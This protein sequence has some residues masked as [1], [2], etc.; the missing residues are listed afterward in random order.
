MNDDLDGLPASPSSSRNANAGWERATIEKLL[1]ATL[2][3]QQAARRWKLFSRL[4]WLLLVGAVVWFFA[5]ADSMTTSQSTPHTAVVEIEGAGAGPTA[6]AIVADI[7]DIAR[8]E[9]GPAFAMPVDS[10]DQAPVADAGAREG[11][12]SP[13]RRREE[14]PVLRGDGCGDRLRVHLVA[15]GAEAR[16]ARCGGARFPRASW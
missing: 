12:G 10:L 11:R 9:Y 3:E 1:F 14:Q 13:V 15:G 7:I 4:L 16:G 5:T 6:S 8:D 2:R